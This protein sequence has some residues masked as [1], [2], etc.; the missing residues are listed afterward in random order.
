MTFEP[1]Y[2]NFRNFERGPDRV[3]HVAAAFFTVRL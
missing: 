3:N 2:L 1:G